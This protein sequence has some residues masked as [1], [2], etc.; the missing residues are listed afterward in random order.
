MHRGHTLL[1]ATHRAP[2]A[3]PHRAAQDD[4]FEGMLI[5]KD[6]MI[7]IPVWSLQH[8]NED[9]SDVRFGSLLPDSRIDLSPLINFPILA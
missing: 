2:I 4:W 1:T 6:S 3:V 8:S 5:P 7:V 9:Y